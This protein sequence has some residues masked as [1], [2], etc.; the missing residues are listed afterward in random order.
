MHV[1]CLQATLLYQTLRL[2]YMKNTIIPFPMR[3]TMLYCVITILSLR[4]AQTSRLDSSMWH[5][6]HGMRHQT[7]TH[8]PI[9]VDYCPQR[10][11]LLK[12]RGHVQ[13]GL[14]GGI[15]RSHDT[16]KFELQTSSA[17]QMRSWRCR[18]AK[19]GGPFQRRR[20]KGRDWQ[21]GSRTGIMKWSRCRI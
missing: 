14:L 3:L 1:E 7:L 17:S 20:R 2:L 18:L 8:P 4:W 13:L 12:S 21:S 16:P 5:H 6:S 9:L 11:T 10:P 19:R 15:Y